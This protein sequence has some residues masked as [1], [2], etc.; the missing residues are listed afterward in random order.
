MAWLARQPGRTTREKLSGR[1]HA[2]GV[3]RN[4][5]ADTTENRLLRS[6]A[7]L[8]AERDGGDTKAR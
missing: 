3:K 4:V 5:S 8:L 1:T 2:L 7:K 6:F